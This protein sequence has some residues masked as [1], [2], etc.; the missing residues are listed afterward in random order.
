MNIVRDIQEI[1]YPFK[2]VK[3]IKVDNDTW[4]DDRCMGR[5]VPFMQIPNNNCY[6]PINPPPVGME[7]IIPWDYCE[8]STLEECEAQFTAEQLEDLPIFVYVPRI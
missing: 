8:D 1:T 6:H 2:F 4:L 7:P 5:V 3:I